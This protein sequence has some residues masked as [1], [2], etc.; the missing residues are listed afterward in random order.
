MRFEAV[1]NR[2]QTGGSG[3]GDIYGDS[4]GDIFNVANSLTPAPSL[5]HTTN[6]PAHHD[7]ERTG[8]A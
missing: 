4:Y 1:L 7:P 5:T 2:L 6:S 8:P 3:G